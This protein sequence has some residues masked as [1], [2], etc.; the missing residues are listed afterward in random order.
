MVNYTCLVLTK[1]SLRVA[2][3]PVMIVMWVSPGSGMMMHNHSI[4]SGYPDHC[5]GDMSVLT[6]HYTGYASLRR[7]RYLQHTGLLSSKLSLLT[8][9]GCFHP[10]DN[11]NQNGPNSPPPEGRGGTARDQQL[12]HSAYLIWAVLGTDL[13]YHLLSSMA[14][15]DQWNG[16]PFYRNLPLSSLP[17]PEK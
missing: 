10:I 5:V 12:A 13:N 8:R 3:L 14:N 17:V 4:G 9:D 7:V 1:S 2:G 6:S 11:Q 16:K 15:S